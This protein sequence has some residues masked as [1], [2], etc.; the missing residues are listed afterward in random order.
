[1]IIYLE[2]DIENKKSPGPCPLRGKA[3]DKLQLLAKLNS[4]YQCS[5]TVANYRRLSHSYWASLQCLWW[6]WA[7]VGTLINH[8][9]FVPLRNH[10]AMRPELCQY[11]LTS[12][13]SSFS[14]AREH[15][16]T[17]LER[18]YGLSG[19]QTRDAS[20][21]EQVEAKTSPP[22]HHRW[23]RGTRSQRNLDAVVSTT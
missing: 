19:A 17:T 14:S 6:Q 10:M 2:F 15:S 16:E 12:N 5:D 23:D 11:P 21:T 22:T 13:R 9:T 7:T 8:S 20:L 18:N 1:M 3:R 4:G